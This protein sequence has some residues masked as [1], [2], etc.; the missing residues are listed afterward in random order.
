[1]PVLEIDF[2]VYFPP[3]ELATW[4]GGQQCLDAIE[5]SKIERRFGF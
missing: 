4:F 2:L 3:E 1:M 5:D